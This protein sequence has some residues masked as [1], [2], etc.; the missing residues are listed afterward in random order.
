MNKIEEYSE[1]GKFCQTDNEKQA[2][3]LL[4]Q[5]K[6]QRKAGKILGRS[7]SSIKKAVERV[8]RRASLHGWSPEHD[9]THPTPDTHILKGTSTLY[10][11]NG[12][13]KQQWVKTNVDAESILEALR[14]AV[15]A[16][17]EDV[18]KVEPVPVDDSIKRDENLLNLYTLSD[19]HVGMLAWEEE[20][21]DNWDLGIAEKTIMRTFKQMVDQSPNTK[22][23]IINN[24][25]DWLHSTGMLPVTP[26]HGHILDQDGRFAKIVRTSIRI[27]RYLVD[28]ALKKHEIVHIK[29][30]E[31]NHD[32]SSSIWL[33][34]MFH[35]LYENEP[36][37][38]VDTS[39][40]P[41]SVYQF[42]KVMLG[43]HHGHKKGNPQ[44]PLLFATE[45]SEIWGDTTFRV[46]HTGHRHH[47]E[48]KEHSGMIVEQH[49]T[50][51]ARDA[52]ASRGGWHSIRRVNSITY[53][54]EYGEVGRI[55][56]SPEMLKD[57]D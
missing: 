46:A 37:V 49:S 4:S 23:C 42:G 14:E 45:F 32:D 29:M 43:F 18:P 1:L 19:A 41:F 34:E 36:R 31:G 20:G 50:I 22:T 52:H 28:L 12:R 3:E 44:L 7:Q 26:S 38:S 51:A 40:K 54:K 11:E 15:E 5:G 24:L 17:K 56:V 8:R 16:L 13:I 53:H 27:I 33:R 2:F 21:G 39:P 25:G 48:I 30:I 6:S 35:T 9:M 10:D 55:Y 47:T 57:I